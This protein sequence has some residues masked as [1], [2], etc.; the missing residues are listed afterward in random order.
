MDIFYSSIDDICDV[1]NDNDEADLK[2]RSSWSIDQNAVMINGYHNE[3]M[4]GMAS[5]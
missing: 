2:E 1:I 4:A 3:W 5:G